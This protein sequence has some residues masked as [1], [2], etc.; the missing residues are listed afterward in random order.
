MQMMLFLNALATVST[1]LCSNKAALTKHTLAEE[2]N[3]NILLIL[4]LRGK[5][6]NKY[7]KSLEF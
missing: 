6:C 3:L 7:A 2:K 1:H 4:K 5:S